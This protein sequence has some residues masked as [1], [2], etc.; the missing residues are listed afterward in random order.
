MRI[1][2]RAMAAAAFMAASAVPASF[3]E[4]ITKGQ[5]EVVNRTAHWLDTVYISQCGTDLTTNWLP[6]RARIR[7]GE[8]YQFDVEPGCWEVDSGR[9]GM[10]GGR[11]RVNVQA[12]RNTI[13]TLS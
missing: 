3:A 5:I 11:V 4:T 13:V 10:G 2:V 8:S 1:L 7:R 9:T 6:P 12:G